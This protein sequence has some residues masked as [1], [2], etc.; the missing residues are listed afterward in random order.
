V[1]V[2]ADLGAKVTALG[3]IATGLL[4][5]GLVLLAGG[6]ALLVV[7]VRRSGRAS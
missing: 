3:W 5:G 4:L 2:R 6:T 1:D 7:A